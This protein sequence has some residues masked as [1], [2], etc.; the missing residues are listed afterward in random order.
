MSDD[1][2]LIL[3]AIG[4]GAL[5]LGVYMVLR[6]I[7]MKYRP[8]VDAFRKAFATY[9]V[10]VIVVMMTAIG[11]YHSQTGLSCSAAGD[12]TQGWPCIL[13]FSLI[14]VLAV[15][16]SISWSYWRV[17]RKGRGLLERATAVDP[18]KLPKWIK[19]YTILDIFGFV[20]IILA[21]LFFYVS[22]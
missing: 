4:F 9:S 11:L 15:S 18:S 16:I 12:S 3:V 13:F 21:A 8:Q 7:E 2:F 22:R 6:I 1:T 5:I 20:I 14:P 17:Y 10:F 19:T